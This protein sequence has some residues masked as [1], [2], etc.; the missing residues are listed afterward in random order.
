MFREF[1]QNYSKEKSDLCEE[2]KPKNENILELVGSFVN[3]II[4]IPWKVTF[5]IFFRK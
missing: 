4:G 5:R 3:I 2:L 1:S